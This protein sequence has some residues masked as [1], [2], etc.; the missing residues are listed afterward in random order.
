MLL[1]GI[2]FDLDNTLMDRDHTFRS[3]AEQLVREHLGHLSPEQQRETVLYMIESDADGYR[4]KDGFFQELLDR[5]PWR[6]PMDMDK[7]KAYYEANYMTHA[8]VMR[9]GVE[10]LRH[11]RSLGLKTGLITNGVTRLQNGKIDLL[12]LRELFD[13]VV[14]SEEA[15]IRKPDERIYKLAL[16]KLGTAAE[17]TII[18]GDHPVNDIWGAARIG[19]KGIW[20]RRNHKWSDD[21]DGEPWAFIDELDEV[22]DIVEREIGA[23]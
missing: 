19:L 2:L 7:L 12:G 18:V 6:Q 1:K 14:I 3:F 17:E 15:G 21:L 23:K 22:A 13:A 16:E 10:C 9:H 11:V 8:Q 4:P 20:L 5:L